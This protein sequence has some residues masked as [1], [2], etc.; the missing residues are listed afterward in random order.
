M[1]DP[2]SPSGSNFDFHARELELRQMNT[3]VDARRSDV[4]Q[5]AEALVAKLDARTLSAP[6]PPPATT[7]T[8][9]TPPHDHGDV[10]AA[11]PAS[12]LRRS[13]ELS[14][15]HDNVRA[16]SSQ[17]ASPAR[18]GGGGGSATA[19]ANVESTV[20]AS[21][22]VSSTTTT[23]TTTTERRTNSRKPKRAAAA[24]AAA[25][26]NT[27][28]SNGDAG[29]N[30]INMGIGAEAAERYARARIQALEDAASKQRD[31]TKEAQRS[32][33]DS[34][35]RIRLL[36]SE[37]RRLEKAVQRSDAKGARAREQA[38]AAISKTNTLEKDVADLRRAL[39][40]AERTHS[41]SSRD[42]KTHHARLNRA[43]LEAEAAKR[44]ARQ[45]RESGH[46]NNN[47]NGV[48]GRGGGG[49]G[50]GVSTQ[51]AARLR[52]ENK[53]LL[54]QRGELLHA[55]KTQMTLIDV[56]K[57]QKMHVEGATLLGFTEAEFARTLDMGDD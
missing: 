29:V 40:D 39:T 20:G 49:K 44:E 54:A 8:T 43:L 46:S 16:R 18:G 35:T 26:A 52:E 27:S 30:G 19:P 41:A 23:T 9:A 37:N 28:M 51:E 31:A 56:L 36:E 15:V 14:G 33:G 55:F 48:S 17:P 34:A 5:R 57:K 53:R 7:T 10:Y 24:A 45:L 21:A 3:R 42:S 2:L 22:S 47:I 12:P 1:H 38:D 25:A 32:A 50:G 6:P 4:V 11:V 13:L